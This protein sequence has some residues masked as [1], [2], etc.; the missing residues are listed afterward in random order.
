VPLTCASESRLQAARAGTRALQAPFFH[1]FDPFWFGPSLWLCREPWRPKPLRY[2][3]LRRVGRDLSI[4]VFPVACS[5]RCRLSD[6]GSE[7]LSPVPLHEIREARRSED[8]RAPGASSLAPL[9]CSEERRRVAGLMLKMSESRR[10]PN[11]RCSSEAAVRSLSAEA[12][13]CVAALAPRRQLPRIGPKTVAQSPLPCVP[14]VES[15]GF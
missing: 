13:S 15:E 10:L 2:D 3:M 12:S 5:R 14:N 8:L 6:S 11:P 9:R 4:R 1:R 7:D